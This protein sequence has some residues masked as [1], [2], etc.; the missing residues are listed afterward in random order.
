MGIFLLPVRNRDPSGAVKTCTVPTLMLT[1]VDATW[2]LPALAKLRKK[3]A[4]GKK[5]GWESA[6]TPLRR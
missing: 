1:G 3:S 5:T 4:L 6:L 2:T